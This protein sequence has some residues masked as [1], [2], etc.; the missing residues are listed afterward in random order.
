MGWR[1]PRMEHSNGVVVALFENRTADVSLEPLGQLV[2]ERIIRMVAER[3]RG[4]RRGATGPDGSRCAE[5]VSSARPRI[6]CVSC[7]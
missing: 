4:S 2:A 3:E 7:L 5:R 6:G 1:V